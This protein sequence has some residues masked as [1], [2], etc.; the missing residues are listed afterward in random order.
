MRY[1]Y[2]GGTRILE[3][4]GISLTWKEVNVL[5]NRFHKRIRNGLYETLD[6]CE[7]T[8]IKDKMGERTE[9]LN[10]GILPINIQI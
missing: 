7:I 10:V 5:H 1:L 2:I 9:F 8:I 6:L 3:K 4:Q